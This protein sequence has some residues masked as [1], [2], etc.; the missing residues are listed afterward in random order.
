L[1]LLL[2][3]PG[4]ASTVQGPSADLRGTTI[5]VESV[6]GPPAP[7]VHKFVATLNEEAATRQIAIVPRGAQALYRVRGYLAPQAGGSIAWAWDIYDAAENRAFRLQG[8]ERSTTGRSNASRTWAER[9][10]ADEQALRR[11]ARAS[12]EQLVTFLAESRGAPAAPPAGGGSQIVASSDDFRPEAAGIFRVSA[13]NPPPPAPG[14][15]TASVPLPPH[16]PAPA[17]ATLAFNN[18]E[19]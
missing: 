12:V 7:V 4:C 5:A 1:L 8:E 17:A 6:D 18:A 3:L 9:T 13:S 16:R 14:A 10:W 15:E 19:R 2:A 11:I